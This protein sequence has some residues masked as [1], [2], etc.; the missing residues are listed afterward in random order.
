MPREIKKYLTK[1][2]F[3]LIIALEPDTLETLEVLE[4]LLWNFEVEEEYEWCSVLKKEIDLR[5]KTYKDNKNGGEEE[6]QEEETSG[7]DLPIQG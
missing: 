7:Q 5:V 2:D 6:K 4:I 1:S 3:A